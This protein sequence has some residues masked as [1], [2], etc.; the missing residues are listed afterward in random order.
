MK[1]HTAATRGAFSA[2]VEPLV[3]LILGG[4]DAAKELYTAALKTGTKKQ[5]AIAVASSNLIVLRKDHDMFDSYKRM[6]SVKEEKLS[7]AQKRTV[8]MNRALLLMSMGKEDELK[9]LYDANK[10]DGELNI[11]WAALMFRKYPKN[12]KKCVDVLQA[13]IKR[14][15]DDDTERRRLCARRRGEKVRRA[16]ARPRP[17]ARCPRECLTDP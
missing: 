13:Y 11:V 14:S 10:D 12:T 17:G 16:G 2:R 5:T 7:F 8:A 1:Q 3:A 9:R 15:G 6:K 4:S